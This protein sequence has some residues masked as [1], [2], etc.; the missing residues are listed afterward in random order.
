MTITFSMAVDR[1]VQIGELGDHAYKAIT[2]PPMTSYERVNEFAQTASMGAAIYAQI[3]G[4]KAGEAASIGISLIALKSSLDVLRQDYAGGASAGRLL[5]DITESIGD[6]AQATGA[7][8]AAN[9]L[10]A[11]F[12]PIITG[13]GIDCSLLGLAINHSDL[14]KM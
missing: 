2:N 8:L 11:G 5:A 9:P 14:V 4:N 10:T 1:G 3:P 6:I 12:A 7:T 13:I